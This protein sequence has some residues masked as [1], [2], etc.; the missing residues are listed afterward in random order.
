M[1]DVVEMIW[2]IYRFYYL[3][4]KI[5]QRMLEWVPNNNLKRHCIKVNV[6]IIQ[7]Q[8]SLMKILLRNE[9]V[10]NSTALSVIH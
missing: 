10:E 1:F 5:N 4:S 3:T 6:A 7:T 8:F 2:K 9:F